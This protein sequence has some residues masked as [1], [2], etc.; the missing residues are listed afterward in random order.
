MSECDYDII[1]LTETGLDDRI[2]SMQLFGSSYNV[3]RCDRNSF[4]SGKRSFGGVL[5][6]VAN[7][8][9]SS[10]AETMNGRCLEQVCVRV[11][12]RGL[13]LLICVVYI[14]P[15]KSQ[16]VNV[17]DSHIASIAELC[18]NSE[19]PVN[20]EVVLICGDYNQPRIVWDNSDDGMM[21]NSSSQLSAAAS[22]LIDG[23]NY[24]N[25]RQANNERN[26]LGRTL[27]LVFC[28]P[29]R[30]FVADV[31]VAPLVLPLD[32]HH[33]ALT[34]SL[35]AKCNITSRPA[36]RRTLPE[37]RVL[38]Y[39]KLDFTAFTDY[40]TSLNWTILQEQ[41]NVD[42]MAA[43]FCDTMYQ[44]LSSNLP[45]VK[46][47]ASPP[48]STQHLRALKRERNCWQRRYRRWKT[49]ETKRNFKLSSDEYRRMN[50][51]LYKRYIMRIQIDLRLKPRNF[52]NFVNSKRKRTSIPKNVYY[53]GTE[54]KSN[55]DSCEL[56]ANYFASVF[57]GDTASALEAVEAAVPV[58]ANLVDLSTFDITTDMIVAAAKK[59]KRS[60]SAG[61]DGIPAVNFLKFGNNPSCFRYSKVEIVGT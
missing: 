46:A 54:S 18:S 45:L 27:D 22:A 37:S 44:W 35:P 56:F 23:M 32:P 26:H 8:H 61:P 59:L 6:A 47:P 11:S 2:N 13:K 33:P 43:I 1:I 5:I 31:C 51:A 36:A 3:F 14:P 38:N 20:D 28:S 42:D 60:F 15:D 58:P 40:L 12:I 21:Y 49:C 24:L 16:L 30:E 48:W 57:A 41:D 29:D 10:I 50:A 34:I 55:S 4:N 39:R 7:E 53:D 52:W 25:L 19:N 9:S 17:I